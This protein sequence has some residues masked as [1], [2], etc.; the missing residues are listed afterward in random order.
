[1]NNTKKEIVNRIVSQ[2]TALYVDSVDYDEMRDEIYLNNN[3]G[4]GQSTVAKLSFNNYGV[5]QIIYDEDATLEIQA[6]LLISEIDS[7]YGTLEPSEI[8]ERL[9]NAISEIAKM[10]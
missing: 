9:Q 6:M 7:D 3:N 8:V 4:N 5:E 1:M 10:F 2:I